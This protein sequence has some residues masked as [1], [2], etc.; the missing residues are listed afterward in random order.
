MTNK[1]EDC[2]SF[3]PE[4][5][6]TTSIRIGTY[7]AESNLVDNTEMGPCFHI[8]VFKLNDSFV[9]EDDDYYEA[10]LTFPVTYINSLIECGFYGIIFKKTDASLKYHEELIDNVKRIYG[11]ESKK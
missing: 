8:F 1:I 7:D 9:M 3:L 4:A 2:Y 6:M 11:K 5:N 10:V